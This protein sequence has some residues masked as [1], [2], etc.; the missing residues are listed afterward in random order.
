MSV[1]VLLLIGVFAALAT[2]HFYSATISLRQSK[3]QA[4]VQ[5]ATLEAESG[6]E[7]LSYIISQQTLPGGVSGTDLLDALADEL[8]DTLDG[9]AA[10]GGESTSYADGVISIPAVSLEP[11]RRFSATVSLN[12]AGQVVLAVNGQSGAV[13]R[14]VAINF[15]AQRQSHPVFE[16]GIAARGPITLENRIDIRGKTDPSE[17]SLFSAAPG[18][19]IT[20]ENRL[21]CDGDLHA[22]RADAD[23]KIEG[24]G[25]IAGVDMNDPAVWDHVHIGVGGV[26]FPSMDPGLFEPYA[27]NIVDSG[28]DTSGEVLENIRVKSGTNPDFSHGTELRGVIYIESGNEVTFSQNSVITGIIVT[29][30]GDGA[31]DSIKFENQ[32]ELY[33]LEDLPDSAEWESLRDLSGCIMLA[34]GFDVKFENRS[35]VLSGYMA[36]ESFKFE[37]QFTGEIKGGI[38]SYGD[39]E[40]KAENRMEITIDRMNYA[41]DPP[42]G[43]VLPLVLRPVSGSYTEQ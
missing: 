12:D 9:T 8:S 7:F 28:T 5:A 3:S 10:L 36:A 35:T 4:D 32:S 30:E 16:Y 20:I 24:N 42:P 40:L 22:G 34:P 38:I 15:E 2:A 1:L 25:T 31:T 6:M 21:T 37:N 26:E 39:G 18:T 33:G 41:T 19:A 23:V 13:N 43:F 29:E 14:S 17:A 11:G 27:T